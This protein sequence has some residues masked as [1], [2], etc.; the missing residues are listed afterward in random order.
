MYLKLYSAKWKL[1]YLGLN[2]L[3]SSFNLGPVLLMGVI[4]SALEMNKVLQVNAI[5]N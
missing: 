2:V 4:E 5:K 3:I 1:S